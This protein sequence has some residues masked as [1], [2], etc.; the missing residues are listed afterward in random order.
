LLIERD[1]GVEED[2]G[3]IGRGI[4]KGLRRGEGRVGRA[5][6][7]WMGES[8]S[9]MEGLTSRERRDMLIF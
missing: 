9:V 1:E 4:G 2:N 5:A 7:S 6:C 8:V 3:G